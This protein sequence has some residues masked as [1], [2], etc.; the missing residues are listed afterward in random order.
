MEIVKKT[1]IFKRHGQKIF[2]WFSQFNRWWK[3]DKKTVEF[4]KN[5]KYLKEIET[6]TNKLISKPKSENI[7]K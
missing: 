5:R 7:G 6:R 1:S 2:A 3:F 4:D